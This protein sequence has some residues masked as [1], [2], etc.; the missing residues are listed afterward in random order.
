MSKITGTEETTS[1]VALTAKQRELVFLYV[2]G[3]TPK[4]VAYETHLTLGAVDS[5]LSAVKTKYRDVGRDAHIRA[6]MR[7]CLIADGYLSAEGQ[8]VDSPSERRKLLPSRAERFG[9]PVIPSRSI[10]IDA[11][12]HRMID[13]AA[14]TLGKSKTEVV[15]CAVSDYVFANHLENR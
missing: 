6:N 11:M 10:K 4:E 3:L 12:T 5:Q 8:P 14:R 15:Q 1:A 9:N 7:E 13:L 2:G